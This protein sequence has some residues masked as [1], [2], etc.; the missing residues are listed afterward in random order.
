MRLLRKGIAALSLVTVALIGFPTAASAEEPVRV[1]DTVTDLTGSISSEVPAMES[2]MVDLQS[3]TGNSLRVVFVDS[4]DSV[5]S[6]DWAYE[7]FTLSGFGSQDSLLAIAVD[8]NQLSVW[9]GGDGFTASELRDA[10]NGD[11]TSA[12][13]D[14]DWSGGLDALAANLDSSGSS[15]SAAPIILIV[16]LIG[17][18]LALWFLS[19]RRKK[20]ATVK[21]AADLGALEKQASQALL[22]VDDGV[23]AAAGELE[24]AKAEFGIEATKQFDTVLSQAQEYVQKAFE[25]RKKLDDEV[26]ETPAQKLEMNQHI[27]K[28]ATAAQQSITEQEEN[29]TQMRNLAATVVE[30]FDQLEVRIG[31]LRTSTGSAPAQIDSLALT[32]PESALV[33]LRTYPAQISTL[34]GAAEKAVAEGRSTA[35]TDKSKAVPYARLAED[36]V[37]QAR[38]LVDQISNA[39]AAFEQANANTQ[40][41]LSSISS[42]ISDAQRLG[43]GDQVIAARKADAEAAVAYATGNSVD[44]IRAF[45]QLTTAENALDAA[46]AAVRTAEENWRRAQ[47]LVERNRAAAHASITEADA[48][49]DRYSR[50]IPQQ[51]RTQLAA[52]KGSFAQATNTANLMEQA[53]LFDRA[54]VQSGEA[55]SVAQR[56]VSE[57]E[58][59]QQNSQNN[60][61]SDF[62]AVLGGMI[63]GSL[64]SGGGHRGHGGFS[65][66]SFGGG[67]GG[68]GFGGGGGGGGRGG[69]FGG[70]F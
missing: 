4:F 66:G 39:R 44:P 15:S 58:R 24:F 16:L 56:G 38:S 5:S 65:A 63:I 46:L 34:L 26:P 27:I 53:Q 40:K 42:D 49:V 32:Y 25:I 35:A 11:V 30:H 70:S 61:G 57:E 2:S 62:G 60:G 17:C 37:R 54:R 9:T 43:R 69:G 7:S 10:I 68:G 23:R 6:D 21:A 59:R 13:H 67:F 29:F 47:Q 1:T 55:Y 22:S 31:E 3:A 18:G 12:W 51:A 36:T 20:A 8:T 41:A 48:Y 52:A 33:T 50:F 45:N 64:L 28:L 14:G 19:S